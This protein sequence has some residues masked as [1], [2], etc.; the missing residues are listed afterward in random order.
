MVIPGTKHTFYTITLPVTRKGILIWSYWYI[1]NQYQFLFS[2]P[3]FISN[4]YRY[5]IGYYTNTYTQLYQTDTE[6]LWSTIFGGQKLFVFNIFEGQ[7]HLDVKKKLGSTNFGVQKFF[8]LKFSPDLWQASHFD[9]TNPF[10][11]KKLPKINRYWLWHNS[12]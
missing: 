10:V 3:E 9:L 1:A 11:V 12:K 7:I 4:W 8:F 5:Y 2:L 6:I